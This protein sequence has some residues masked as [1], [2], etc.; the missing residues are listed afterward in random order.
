[1]PNRPARPPIWRISEPPSSRSCL[2]SNLRVVDSTMRAIGR[3]N[4]MPMASVA[5]STSA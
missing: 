1:M 2:P 3:F 5:T 4:P